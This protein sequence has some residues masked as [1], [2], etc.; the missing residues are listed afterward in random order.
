MTADVSD[1]GRESASVNGHRARSDPFGWDLPKAGGEDPA[2]PSAEAS[3]GV[4]KSAF[5]S[6]K[7]RLSGLGS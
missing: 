5:A 4:V 3:Q 7:L 1:I 6:L 2:D